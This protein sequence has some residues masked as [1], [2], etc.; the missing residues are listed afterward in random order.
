MHNGCSLCL[1]DDVRKAQM[2]NNNNNNN[3]NL[4]AVFFDV[5]KAYDMLWREGLMITSYSHFV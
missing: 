1:E 5:E 3:N 4:V 2:N